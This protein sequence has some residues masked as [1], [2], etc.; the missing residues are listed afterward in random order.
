MMIGGHLPDSFMSIQEHIERKLAVGDRT[1]APLRGAPAA[2][3][4]R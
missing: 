4:G 2:H 3:G 1:G